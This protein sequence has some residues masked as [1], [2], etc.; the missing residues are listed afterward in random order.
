MTTTIGS[1]QTNWIFPPPAPM[2]SPGNILINAQT[3]KE[4]KLAMQRIDLSGRV[5]PAGALLRVTHSF[6]CEGEKPME[7]LYVF[8][9]PRN[10]TLRRFIVKGD[11]FEV[12]SKLSPREE[13]RKEYEA[14]VEAGHLSVLAEGN[15]DGMVTLS[16]G[17]VRPEETITVMLEI[18]SGVDVQDNKFRFRFPFTLAPNYHAQAKAT[19]TADGVRTELP[20][21][22]FGDLILPEWKNDASGLHQIS[23]RLHVEA[24]GMLEAVASPS[25]R[26]L[27]RPKSDTSAEVEL[28]GNADIPNRDLVVDVMA[29]QAAVTTFADESIIN[30]NPLTTHLPANA[31]QWMVSLP[32]TSIPKAKSAPRRVCFVVDRS[33]SMEGQ[34]IDRAKLALKACLSALSPDDEFGI[35]SFGNDSDSFDKTMAKA[36]DNNRKQAAKFIQKIVANGG[37]VLAPAL[38]EAVEI[39]GGPG[40]DIFLI[41]DGEVMDTGSIL[42]QSAASGTRIHVLGIGSASQDRFLDALARR[43]DGVQ[44]MIGVNEDVG[45]AALSLFSSVRQPVQTDVIASVEMTDGSSAPQVYEFDTIWDGKAI[46]IMDKGSSNGVLPGKVNLTWKDGKATVDLA[47]TVRASPDGLVAL[48]WAGQRVEDLE[49]ALDMSKQGPARK[50]FEKE[51]K[52]IST[53]YGLASRVMSLT[54]VVHRAGDRAED[55]EQKQVAVGT[56]EGMTLTPAQ[57]YNVMSAGLPHSVY[58]QGIVRSAFAATTFGSSAGSGFSYSSSNIPNVR[59]SMRKGGVSA[60]LG[61]RGF[62]PPGVYTDIAEGC[63]EVMSLDSCALGE[64]A[65]SINLCCEPMGQD[66]S[67][68]VKTIGSFHPDSAKSYTLGTGVDLLQIL[69]T[70]EADGG[71]PGKDDDA[72]LLDTVL[73]ALAA[74]DE[75]FKTGMPM[76]RLHISRMADFILA[77][78]GGDATLTKLV[79]VFLRTRLSCRLE[80]D[81][82]AL[83][84]IGQKKAWE[85][86]RKAID[87]A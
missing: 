2:P 3:G 58:P 45:A 55:V 73:V 46:Q 56:P 62:N 43:T 41:T 70:L 14:G 13:A 15:I 76:Y 81:W 19:Q 40:G 48:L 65:E 61:A 29:K 5:S 4:I 42:E 18:V 75:D 66:Y 28:S 36:T 80:G 34:P 84:M 60:M 8:M 38:G 22:V 49:S 50:A 6:K 9:L 7:A 79:D 35:V 11:D 59:H 16:V 52:E 33:G 71:L 86:I 24:G 23:F 57:T 37:T 83:R 51:L 26:V 17:Q 39:L 32:S 67:P 1:V 53:T 54:A 74:L 20:Q 44:K 82:M 64:T 68:E 77:H 85:A 69:S 31:P 27:V 47:G 12:E 87:A 78:A 21:D 25:H 63:E 30:K 72:R 10:G